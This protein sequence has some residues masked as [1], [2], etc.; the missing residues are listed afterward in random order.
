MV[1]DKEDSLDYKI[2][3]FM[4]EKIANKIAEDDGSIIHIESLCENCYLNPCYA[5]GPD[6]CVRTEDG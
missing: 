1:K 5:E 2:G 3:Y 6:N 4:G